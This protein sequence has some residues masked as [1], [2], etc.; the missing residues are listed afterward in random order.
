MLLHFYRESIPCSCLDEKYKE[1]DSDIEEAETEE[2]VVESVW[3]YPVILQ[4]EVEEFAA[5]QEEQEIVESTFE[6]DQ[7]SYDALPDSY[8]PNM[9][10]DAARWETNYECGHQNT[11]PI[12]ITAQEC[13]LVE[14]FKKF[15]DIFTSDYNAAAGVLNQKIRAAYHATREEYAGIW[16]SA[17]IMEYVSSQFLNVG[18]QYV[19]D[20]NKKQ[21]SH[22]AAIAYCFEQHIACNL[23]R[24]RFTMNWAK[25]NELYF[26]P[27]EHTLVSF[28]KKRIS[29][30]CLD[31]RHKRGKSIKKLGICY[32]INCPHPNGKAER[33]LT[34]CCSLCRRVNYCC[35]E[36]H[37]DNWKVHKSYCYGYVQRDSDYYE[38]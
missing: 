32:N 21:A 5:E 36:C 4:Q 24:E 34:K 23:L 31:K 14:G 28:F 6:A 13:E 3:N 10:I 1:F 35:R 27:D 26:E 15:L 8:V 30:S 12:P 19:L 9:Q 20:G 18:T 22:Y 7:L 11:A 29:C 33:S 25:M 38:C 2:Q 17:A 16:N 37:V